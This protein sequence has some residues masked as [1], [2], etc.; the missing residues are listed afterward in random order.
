MEGN[1][2]YILGYIVC[3]NSCCAFLDRDKKSK[4]HGV[5]LDRPTKVHHYP[6][7]YLISN[8]P[9]TME[10]T[11][12]VNMVIEISCWNEGIFVCKLLIDDDTT[13]P[14]HLGNKIWWISSGKKPLSFFTKNNNNRV[15]DSGKHILYLAQGYM[16]KRVII[17]VASRFKM[18]FRT[19]NFVWKK[20]SLN[21]FRVLITILLYVYLMRTIIVLIPDLESTHNA[22][23][24]ELTLW[25]PK[26]SDQWCTMTP[27][28]TSLPYVI[29]SFHWT[30]LF[31]RYTDG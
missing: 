29:N 24:N 7:I 27:N 3:S 22:V 15:R 23:L 21:T 10:Y 17:I 25:N 31:P 18:R 20:N 12:T 1:I 28:N 11:V 2:Y 16:K 9:N 26:S 14:E 6:S 30:I 5:A 19:I 13:M 4:Q 8:P